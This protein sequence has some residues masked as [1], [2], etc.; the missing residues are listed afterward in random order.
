VFSSLPEEIKSLLLYCYE[1]SEK[2]PESMN[3]ILNK[4]A[5][6]RAYYE[7]LTFEPQAEKTL[8]LTE[9]HRDTV[10][11]ILSL[12]EKRI[13]LG[14]KVAADKCNE[15]IL[16]FKALF[17]EKSKE[18]LFQLGT[19]TRTVRQVYSEFGEYVTRLLPCLLTT[20]EV[21]SNILPLK[22]ETFDIVIFDE[23]SQLSVENAVP[24]L[25][26]GKTAIVVGDDKQLPPLAVFSKKT[27]EQDD[28]NIPESVVKARSLLDLAVTVFSSVELTHHYRSE[29]RELI[30]FSNK[31]FYGGRLRVVPNPLPQ[32]DPPIDYI[33]VRGKRINGK[34]EREAE[35]A[36]RLA[37][38][39]S[40]TGTVGIIAF[41]GDQSELIAQKIEKKM[42]KDPAFSKRWSDC[43]VKSIENVQGEEKDVIIFS[44]GYAPDKNGKIYARFGYLGMD[45]GEKRLNVAVT[46]AKK[47]MVIVT[48]IDPEELS[49]SNV[50]NDGPKLLK[51]FLEYAKNVSERASFPLFGEAENKETETEKEIGEK[52]REIG[53]DVQAGRSVDPALSLALYDRERNRFLLG[54]E[55]DELSYRQGGSVYERDV[56]KTDFFRRKGWKII[57]I[58]TRDWWLSP[59]NVIQKIC[60]EAEKERAKKDL[61]IRFSAALPLPAGAVIPQDGTWEIIEN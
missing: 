28:E 32:A 38:S 6:I 35:E 48:S 23:A 13:E 12:Q 8:S 54:I 5:P 21:V 55:T 41:N 58:W 47:K 22:K 27:A 56:D 40:K 44:V 2:T 14:R 1:H 49:V 25:Y 18:F 51:R 26:R 29:R 20:P 59:Q 36:A 10:E 19:P 42:L 3:D 4:V 17:K 30:D 57:R 43:F 50:K 45:G 34:N 31:Y 52:L 61:S 53:Y 39:Y 15:N 60:F 33:K 11:T 37:V 9:R 7:L 46:R 16:G 24:S